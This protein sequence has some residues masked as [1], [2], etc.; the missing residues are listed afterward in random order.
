MKILDCTLR[1]GG[2]YN[3]WNFSTKLVNEYLNTMSGSGVDTV[4]L[5]FRLKK[6]NCGDYGFITEKKINNL[7]LNKKINYSIMINGKDYI[8]DKEINLKLL[9][10]YFVHKD[11]S[12]VSI[13]R[14]AINLSDINAAIKLSK[15][16]YK[17]GYIVYLNIMQ[18]T[19]LNLK[20]LNLLVKKI[21]D[22]ECISVLYIADSLG[23]LTKNNLIKIY[24]VIKKIQKPLGIHAHN[25]LNNALGN[26]IMAYKLGFK[27]LDSTIMG[28]GR[29][30]GN[31]KTEELLF[32]LQSQKQIKKKYNSEIIYKLIF[33]YFDVL[34][35]KYKWGPNLFYYM[36]AK[37]QIHPT[38]IQKMIEDKKYS[39]KSIIS[40]INIL[41]KL[42]S[43]KFDI[44]I[45]NNGIFHIPNLKFK[46]NWDPKKNF[47]KNDILII[48]PGKSLN[49]YKSKI[50]KFIKNASPTVLCLNYN[51]I[52]DK[53]YIDFYVSCNFGRLM[54][55]LNDY[56]ETT[57]PLIFPRYLISE[58]NT[59]LNKIDILNFGVKFK[60][61]TFKIMKNKCILPDN[62]SLFYALCVAIQ[63]KPKN[64]FLAGVDGY[65]K[66][67]LNFNFV[68]KYI[69]I[70]NS[71]NFHKKVTSIT[72]TN[73]NFK[74]NGK[75][76][77]GSNFSHS[78]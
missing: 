46:G 42:V 53:K 1:D 66:N 41:K 31:T 57:K 72:P 14:I 48:G 70:F 15:Y 20:Q 2:Y 38:Y 62:L 5:G 39:E 61:N 36:S 76:I 55:E 56:I 3:N 34:Y 54:M 33:D 12:K 65:K 77:N 73:F 78:S 45:L 25:N 17:K 37:H 9:N 50:K 13:I 29:G 68:N 19:S 10:D 69:K 52:L 40:N 26:T 75:I 58:K 11:R 21:K 35:K 7:K 8:N 16:F 30:A 74:Y 24:K 32:E 27:Y 22:T 4:E 67:D 6:K 49:T 64:I 59:L 23:D 71:Y 43:K 28:M 51:N 18:I 60:K 44:D 47:Y 63:S